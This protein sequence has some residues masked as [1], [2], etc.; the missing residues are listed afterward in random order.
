MKKNKFYIFIIA[1]LGLLVICYSLYLVSKSRSYQF[2]GELTDKINTNEKII[3][4]TFDDAPSDKTDEILALLAK[5]N[6]KATFYVI[7]RNA[8]EYPEEIKNIVREGHELGNHSYSHQRMIFKSPAFIKN[9]IEKT[10]QLI[11]SA[12]YSGK[13]TFRPPNG[14]K[15]FMLPWYL[16]KNDRKTIMWNI[17]PDTYCQGDADAIVKYTLEN[18]KPGSIILMHPFCGQECTA[19]REALPKIIYELESKG[20]QFQ[21]VS[22]LLEK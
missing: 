4:L 19:D 18:I 13:I 9:E 11:R 5:K 12:G 2:F 17:E 7:G 1:T 20:Y 8:E 6:I 14:K 22:Q 16:W 3:A 10:D 15:L 21:M